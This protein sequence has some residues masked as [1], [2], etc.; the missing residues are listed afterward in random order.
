MVGEIHVQATYLVHAGGTKFYEVIHFYNVDAKKFTLV[1]RWGKLAAADGGGECKVETYPTQRKL[2]EAANKIISSKQG[3][4]YGTATSAHGFNPM[5]V[6]YR[7]AEDFN[8]ILSK[9]YSSGHVVKEVLVNM[10]I[11]ELEPREWIP[12]DDDVVSETPEP[13]PERDEDYGSW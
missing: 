13:E 6:S 11:E 8:D 2:E 10:G 5:G 7:S 1:K 4:D 9:H 3:R 12:T